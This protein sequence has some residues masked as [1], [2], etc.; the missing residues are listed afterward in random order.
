MHRPLLVAVFPVQKQGLSKPELPDL[1]WI[2]VEIPP[3]H[4]GGEGGEK[5]LKKGV[6]RCHDGRSGFG[7][8]QYLMPFF[9]NFPIFQD[10]PQDGGVFPIDF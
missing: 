10:Q 2:A 9:T 5:I 1:G 6:G 4:F 8:G 7:Y 3:V